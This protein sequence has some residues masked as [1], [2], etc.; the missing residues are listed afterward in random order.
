MNAA[1]LNTII[2]LY[3]TRNKKIVATEYKNKLG[4]PA[5]F[6]RSLFSALKNLSGDIGASNIIK[7]HLSDCIG[8][9]AGK[10]LIDLDTPTDY[11]KHTSKKK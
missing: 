1:H 3:T 11:K 4:V 7:E 2:D 9:K 6:D 5:I 10:K 8:V